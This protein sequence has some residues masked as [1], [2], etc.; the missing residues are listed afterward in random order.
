MVKTATAQAGR[1]RPGDN[2]VPL[3]AWLWRSYVKAALIPLLLIEFGFVAIYWGT[4][5]VVYDRSAAAITRISTDGVRDAEGRWV[6]R[7]S[8]AHAWVEAWVGGQWQTY[9]ATPSGATWITRQSA[10]GRAMKARAS[11]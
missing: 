7:D 3:K 8:D 4:S 2:P 10:G 5:Q 1:K 11:A 9:D 6:V